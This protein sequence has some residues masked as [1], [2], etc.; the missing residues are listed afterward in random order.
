MNLS[1]EDQRTF[2]DLDHRVSV[3][4]AQVDHLFGQAHLDVPTPPPAPTPIGLEKFANPVPAPAPAALTA[5]VAALSPDQR[6]QI[7]ALLSAIINPPA[8]TPAAS[9]EPKAE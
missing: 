5:A 7:E 9:S 1:I 4:E 2:Q 3:L 8:P 6:A